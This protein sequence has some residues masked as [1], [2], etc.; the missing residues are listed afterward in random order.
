MQ[1]YRARKREML[2]G[3]GDNIIQQTME[4][5]STDLIMSQTFEQE[6]VSTNN[7]SQ[8]KPRLRF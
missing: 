8:F 2:V 5:S 3:E 4:V 7:N 1:K 6:F